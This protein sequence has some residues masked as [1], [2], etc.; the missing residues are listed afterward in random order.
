VVSEGPYALSFTAQKKRRPHALHGSLE[1]H[2]EH[3]C[4]LALQRG[5]G[6]AA[7]DSD[8][9]IQLGQVS[10]NWPGGPEYSAE[11]NPTR[12]SSSTGC[13]CFA[14]AYSDGTI[15][16][17]DESTMEIISM[18]QEAHTKSINFLEF[19]PTGEYLA[20]G[21]SDG[22]KIW[23]VRP[24]VSLGIAA[25]RLLVNQTVVNSSALPPDHRGAEPIHNE[26][27]NFIGEGSCWSNLDVCNPYKCS[28]T[29][30]IF[31]AFLSDR[32]CKLF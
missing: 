5:G 11:P 22:L 23:K 13:S 10:L 27:M 16:I 18:Q 17:I 29:S 9:L 24:E 15:S 21:G 2:S 8:G 25:L 3:L 4:S 1:D 28:H 30:R 32:L 12:V 6:I 20:S 31:C 19:D 7:V 26:A 14:L